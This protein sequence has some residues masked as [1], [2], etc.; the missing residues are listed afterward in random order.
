MQ[1]VPTILVVMIQC[2]DWRVISPSGVETNVVDMT[3][4]PGLTIPRANDLV[5]VPIPRFSINNVLNP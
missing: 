4:S 3:E 2:F 5:C 1:E